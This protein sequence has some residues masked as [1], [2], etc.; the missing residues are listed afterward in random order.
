VSDL[1]NSLIKMASI[2][3]HLPSDANLDRVCF[4]VTAAEWD[5][6]KE[7]CDNFVP[8]EERL[9]KGGTLLKILD[10]EVRKR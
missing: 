2:L 3:R 6:L 1:A 7:F 5:E 9:P 10:I 8:I 4:L